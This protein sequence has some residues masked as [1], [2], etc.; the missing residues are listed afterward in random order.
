MAAIHL[1]STVALDGTLTVRGLPL[2]AGHSVEV[3]VRDRATVNSDSVDRYPLRGK[4]IQY[5]DPFGSVGEGDW[6]AL[7]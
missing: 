5:K 1:Q 2:L 3:L 6:A 7:Q 4:A